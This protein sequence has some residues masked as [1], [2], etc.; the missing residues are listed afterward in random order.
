MSL[1]YLR[2]L[3]PAMTVFALSCGTDSRNTATP[4]RRTREIGPAENLVLAQPYATPS[5]QNRSKGI[6]WPQGRLP[7][8]PSGFTVS[9]F[10]EKL[11]N[12]RWTYQLP[13]GDVLAVESIRESPNRPQEKSAN[14]ITLFRDTNKDGSPTSARFF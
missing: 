3:T 11:D 12:L 14:R 1:H 8:V 5:A 2:Y 9:L 4:E 6:G 7:T 10:A 13:N